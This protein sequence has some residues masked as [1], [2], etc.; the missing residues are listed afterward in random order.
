MTQDEERFLNHIDPE[1]TKFSSCDFTGRVGKVRYYA[2][3]DKNIPEKYLEA[4]EKANGQ[5]TILELDGQMDLLE[6]ADNYEGEKSVAK[7]FRELGYGSIYPDD[8]LYACKINDAMVYYYWD[9]EVES[10]FGDGHMV[11][12]DLTPELICKP[13]SPEDMKAVGEYFMKLEQR[14]KNLALQFGDAPEVKLVHA[15]IQ[16][17]YSITIP[18]VGLLEELYIGFDSFDNPVL[19]H[20]KEIDPI[21]PMVKDD[22]LENHLLFML[23]RLAHPRTK[24]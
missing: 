12:L 20:E 17:Y 3:V 23:Y 1:R 19:V 4:V 10:P 18:E 5:Y 9:A 22:D 24:E 8:P 7:T 14:A 21:I 11:T 15:S 6:I 13:I 2:L 16:P